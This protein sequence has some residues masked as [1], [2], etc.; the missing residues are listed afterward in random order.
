[1]PKLDLNN[2]AIIARINELLAVRVMGWDITGPNTVNSLSTL[3]V[4]EGGSYLFR[5]RPHTDLNQLAMV[6]RRLA[7]THG[8]LVV[9]SQFQHTEW[10][11]QGH[12]YSCAVDY[13]IEEVEIFTVAEVMEAVM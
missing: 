5:W 10:W 6:V 11:E 9:W 13:C 4:G 12:A 1:M 7:A 3:P 8:P 2:P